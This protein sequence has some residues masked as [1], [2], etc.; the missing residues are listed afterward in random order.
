MLVGF[1]DADGPD[2]RTPAERLTVPMKPVLVAVIDAVADEPTLILSGRPL[3][4]MAK[5]LLT[6]SVTMAVCDSEPLL[7]VTV[8]R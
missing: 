2:G 8:T 3:A 7:A 1:K 5:S 6:L 4:E